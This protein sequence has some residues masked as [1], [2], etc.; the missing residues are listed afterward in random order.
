MLTE[1][2]F[3]PIAVGFRRETLL[4]CLDFLSMVGKWR[5]NRSLSP[6]AI[7]GRREMQ[8]YG[9]VIERGCAVSKGQDVARGK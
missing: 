4:F 2:H 7:Y 3:V 9:T 8:Q 1:M 5:M 6:I